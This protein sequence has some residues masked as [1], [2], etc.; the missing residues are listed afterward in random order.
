MSAQVAMQNALIATSSAQ[1]VTVPCNR[2]YSAIVSEQCFNDLAL[3]CVPDL[4]LAG[5]CPD[6]EQVSLLG[7]LDACHCV[8]WSDVV[9]LSYLTAGCGPEVDARTKTHCELVLGRPVHKVQIKVVLQG[10]CIQH[11]ERCLRDAS[12][13]NVGRFEKAIFIE[14]GERW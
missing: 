8:C 13:F 10:R 6:G 12:L 5:V 3:V 1:E 7:P 14:A 2:T 11:F 4:E 9:Q